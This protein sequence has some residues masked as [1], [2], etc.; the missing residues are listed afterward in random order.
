MTLTIELTPQEDR[1][2][3]VNAEAQG[4]PIEVY[5]HNLIEMLPDERAELAN[6]QYEAT[7][8]LFQQWAEEDS[9]MSANEIAEAERE[10]VD[11]KANINETRA[12]NGE[13]LLYK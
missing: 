10:L 3:R 12:L 4:Q 1:R 8:A 6:K 7:T 5:L 11:F 2:L 13:R 9:E